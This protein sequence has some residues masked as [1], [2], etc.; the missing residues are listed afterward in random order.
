MTKFVLEL[1][2]DN[3]VIFFLTKGTINISQSVGSSENKLID[4]ITT[5]KDM[6]F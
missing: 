6:M 5:K 4:F 2:W 3:G 1:R